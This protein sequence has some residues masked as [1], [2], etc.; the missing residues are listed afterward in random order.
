MILRF[1][2]CSG[3]PQILIRLFVALCSVWGF[4]W[5]PGNHRSGSCMLVARL[6]TL[7]CN[8]SKG[9][10]SRAPSCSRGNCSWYWI[11]DDFVDGEEWVEEE[12]LIGLTVHTLTDSMWMFQPWCIW[13]KRLQSLPSCKN[14]FRAHVLCVNEIK[15]LD[16]VQLL[17]P[18][19]ETNTP[20][21]WVTGSSLPP[22]SLFVLYIMVAKTILDTVFA[23]VY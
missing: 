9:H 3:E 14:D 20:I 17:R 5:G 2:Y 23:L 19:H 13:A 22:P 4:L 1:N 18:S 11:N 7:R 16:S 15:W 21:S 6:T 8:E 10:E 12:I